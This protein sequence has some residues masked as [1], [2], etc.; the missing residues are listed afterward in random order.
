MKKWFLLSL[1]G[2]AL[3]ACKSNPA[4]Q[5]SVR[6]EVGIKGDWTVSSV[7]YP[8][9][10]VIKVNAFGLGEAQCLKGSQWHFVSNNN[11]G[12]MVL[13]KPGCVA[14]DSSITWFINKEGNFVFKFLEG[15]KAKT[16]VDGYTLRYT[17]QNDQSFQLIDRV[18]VAGKI[19]E[20]TYQF[21][22]N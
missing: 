14:F 4:T 8:G 19:V 6:S 7:S 22:R 2:M 13:S 11:T 9:S 16:V 1:I 21:N 18:N 15:A 17:P 3:F 5:L 12:N 10:E 20:V